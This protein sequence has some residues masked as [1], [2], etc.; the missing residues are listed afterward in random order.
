MRVKIKDTWYNSAS[1]PICIQ[2]SESEQ[3]QIGRMK[4]FQGKF[5]VFPDT[6]KTSREEKLAW[7]DE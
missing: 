6:E 2:V 7:M 5:A 4:N 1:E 3:E